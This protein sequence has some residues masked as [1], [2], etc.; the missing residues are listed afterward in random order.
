MALHVVAG[1]DIPVDVAV[2]IVVDVDVIADFEL[3]VDVAVSMVEVTALE[4]WEVVLFNVRV[5]LV[6]VECVVIVAIFDVVFCC[7]RH[8]Q[9]ELTEAVFLAHVVRW[10]GI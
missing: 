8:E 4:I 9:P 7:N 5:V 6:A 2:D 3:P 10:V 1:F